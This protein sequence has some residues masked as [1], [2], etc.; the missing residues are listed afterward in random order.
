MQR[1]LEILVKEHKDACS[2]GFTK[3]SAIAKHAG[4]Q[5]HVIDWEDTN[6]LD[7]GTS[8]A[9]LLV[10]EA[11]CFNDRGYNYQAAGSQL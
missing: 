7:K 3:K 10:K 2:K 8:P 4:Y 1:Q 6:V 11:L 9:Q 5:Q